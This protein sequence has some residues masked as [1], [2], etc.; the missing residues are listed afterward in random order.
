[1]LHKLRKCAKTTRAWFKIF[2]D[3]RKGKF[4]MK[5]KEDVF[6]V[7]SMLNWRNCK[8]CHILA[9]RAGSINFPDI[10]LNSKWTSSSVIIFFL[11]VINKKCSMEWI[12]IHVDYLIHLRCASSNTILFALISHP[13]LHVP[14]SSVS[15]HIFYSFFSLL[16]L[17]G[18]WINSRWME[19][20][21]KEGAF[22]A[23]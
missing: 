23:T 20:E 6:T 10:K 5:K 14:Y 9:K 16:F 4:L 8:D 21:Q 22:L 15:I 11:Y 7:C 1:M 2:A 13:F 18:K 19:C 12:F 17:S 3:A